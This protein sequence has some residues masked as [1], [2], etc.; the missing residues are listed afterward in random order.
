MEVAKDDLR[1]AYLAWV[2]KAG[3]NWY[4]PAIGAFYE[5]VTRM[6]AEPEPWKDRND[7]EWND[8]KKFKGVGWQA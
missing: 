1:E 2:G 4:A 6:G 5:S 7:V 8:V 3:Q